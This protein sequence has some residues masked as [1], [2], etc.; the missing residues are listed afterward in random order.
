MAKLLRPDVTHK[1]RGAVGMAIRVTV[2][3][4]YSSARMLRS[5]VLCLVELLLRK[6]GQEQAQAL[7]LLR[8]Q[9]PV[10][11]FVV[12]IKCYQL[13]L[14]HIAEVRTRRQINGWREFRQ[15]TLRH[16][17]V[18]IETSQASSLLL[19]DLLDFSLREEHVAFRQ[20][21]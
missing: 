21:V 18:E 15:E 17:V 14:R 3:A 2:Q 5:S 1:V 19:F 9:N 13:A 12:V 4:S 16:I 20:S 10:E 7:Q 11:Q 8:I 6:C